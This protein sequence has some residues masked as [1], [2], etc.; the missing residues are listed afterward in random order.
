[1]KFKRYFTIVIIPFGGDKE[2]QNSVGLEDIKPVCES[3]LGESL[4]DMT[5]KTE[6]DAREE[7]ET[8][9]LEKAEELS[10]QRIEEIEKNLRGALNGTFTHSLWAVHVSWFGLFELQREFMWEHKFGRL[11]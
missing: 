9:N 10:Y 4:Q 7:F 6:F 2:K 8:E 11:L 1:M 5:C 3:V